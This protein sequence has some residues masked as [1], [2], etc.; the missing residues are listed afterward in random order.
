MP[1]QSLLTQELAIDS[2]KRMDVIKNVLIAMRDELGQVEK[3][4]MLPVNV[5]MK[6]ELS[7]K[8]SL[9]ARGGLSYEDKKQVLETEYKGPYQLTNVNQVFPA[10]VRNGQIVPVNLFMLLFYFYEF[11]GSG[12][13]NTA[14]NS[15][16]NTKIPSDIKMMREICKK[17]KSPECITPY[18]ALVLNPSLRSFLHTNLGRKHLKE[19]LRVIVTKLSEY[20]CDKNSSNVYSQLKN[21]KSVMNQQKRALHADYYLP[22]GVPKNIKRLFS[23]Y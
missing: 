13:V 17:C 14:F 1:N 11:S 10:F 5:Q 23:P 4:E 18:H 19:Q 8:I 15:L 3:V 16:I 2:A 20:G 7:A 22:N 9:L 21:V 6:K 12:D